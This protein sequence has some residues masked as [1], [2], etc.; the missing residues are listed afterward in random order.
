[1]TITAGPRTALRLAFALAATLALAACGRG[2]APA[3]PPRPVLVVHPAP[4]ADASALAFAGEV[5]ARE[6]SALSFRVGG[7]LVRRFVDVGDKVDRG[8]LLAELDPG[9]LKLQAQAA[10]AQLAAAEAERARA[11]A[12]RARFAQLA[13]QQLVSRSALDAQDA[14][15]AAAAGQAKA[16]RANF[17]VARN[18]AGYSQLRAPRAGV[19]AA[20]QAE[21]G[22]V[23]AA[24][25]PVFTL[26]GDAGREIAIALP[27]SVI[28]GF[29]VGQPVLVELWNAAGTRL[30]GTIRE[31]APAADPQTRT[32][33][34]RVALRGSASDAVE[35]GQ[36]ARVYARGGSDPGGAA[37]TVPLSAI[38]RG[39]NGATAVWVVD[40]ATHKLRSVPV[41]LGAFGEDRVPVLRGVAA[42]D[43]I[44][45][46]GGHLLRAGEMVAPVDRDNRPVAPAAPAG[47][48]P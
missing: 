10:Q 35:L 34:A 44:V 18:Q 31:I 42:S 28:R 2:D 39:D 29:H 20:R 48:A 8:D 25:Q 5:R 9:D 33:A 46:A 22:Q 15:L 36:S 24:G 43:W 41:R 27:E 6:E 7:N 45:A 23:V 12:D 30:P 1:M 4:A 38:Q 37:L 19:I 40:A 16:A 14:A 47:K 3:T 21:A 11:S 17:D 13:R 32:Y 26:A